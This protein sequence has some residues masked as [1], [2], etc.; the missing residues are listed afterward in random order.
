MESRGDVQAGT[1]MSVISARQH[2][3]NG[4]DLVVVNFFVIS[5]TPAEIKVR[6]S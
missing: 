4:S 6:I 2:Q 3:T 1:R 5:V